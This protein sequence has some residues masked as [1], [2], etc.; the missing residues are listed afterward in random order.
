MYRQHES[1][2]YSALLFSQ[3]KPSDG[4]MLRSN[5]EAP[6]QVVLA[7]YEQSDVRRQ[8]L[9]QRLMRLLVDLTSCAMFSALPL[10]H[11]LSNHLNLLSATAVSKILGDLPTTS[12]G[13]AFKAAICDKTL[14]LSLGT[15][16]QQARKVRAAQPKATDGTPGSPS[17]AATRS[18]LQKAYTF[19]VPT[20]AKVMEV[21]SSFQ[22]KTTRASTGDFVLLFHLVVAAGNLASEYEGQSD[23]DRVGTSVV[24]DGRLEKAIVETFTS[25]GHKSSDKN[26]GVEIDKMTAI[27]KMKCEVWR[28]SF[29]L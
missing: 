15:V 28:G 3:I 9:G 2:R 25:K 8:Y 12:R 10:L 1:G 24:L 18:T 17:K 14:G 21:L 20:A 16:Q 13:T 26:F 4:S 6:L 7:C 29:G 27:L 19:P 5:A 23:G 22:Q 11:S